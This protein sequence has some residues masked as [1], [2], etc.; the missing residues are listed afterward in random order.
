MCGSVDMFGPHEEIGY[1][2]GLAAGRTASAGFNSASVLD[3]STLAATVAKILP[4]EAPF[5][6]DYVLKKSLLFASL[7]SQVPNLFT[8]T[9]PSGQCR[10]MRTCLMCTANA[11]CD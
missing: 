2:G 6:Q 8:K 7:I 1:P 4:P 9:L 5:G 10:G 11:M 3:G